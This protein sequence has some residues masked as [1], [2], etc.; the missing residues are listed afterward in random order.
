MT[1]RHP[2]E[3]RWSRRQF[4]GKAAGGAIAV[5][6]LAT[7]LAACSKPDAG[8]GTG[9]GTSASEI[10]IA[11]LENPVELPVTMDTI[12]ADTPIES[13]PLVLYNWADYIHKKVVAE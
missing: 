8:G 7:I 2:M 3:N 5:P 9:S 4:L 12:A 6:S 13:G 11:T 1:D 10:P